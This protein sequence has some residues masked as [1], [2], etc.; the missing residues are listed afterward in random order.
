M[1][2]TDRKIVEEI[3]SSAEK[4]NA[5]NDFAEFWTS[6][7]RVKGALKEILKDNFCKRFPEKKL[8]WDKHNDFSSYFWESKDN[9]FLIFW[10]GFCQMGFGKFDKN[11]FPV[12]I[13]SELLEIIKMIPKRINEIDDGTWVYCDIMYDKNLNVIDDVL[14]GLEILFKNS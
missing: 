7:D 1:N 13:R 2:S 14:N 5:A 11:N 12:K 9:S 3:Y 6:R 8:Q 10:D 4:F